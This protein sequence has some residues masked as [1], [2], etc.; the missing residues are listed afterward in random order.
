MT[1]RPEWILFLAALAWLA[2]PARAQ[3]VPAPGGGTDSA[4]AAARAYVAKSDRYL[5]H[6]RL[7]RGMKGYG[8]TVLEGIR[9]VRFNAEI[10]SVMSGTAAQQSVIMARLSGQGLEK[11]GV[12]QGMSGSPVYVRD[13]RDGKDKIIGA[14]AFAWFAQKEP[15][16]GIQ[17]ITQMLAI[18]GVLPGED[19]AKDGRK[20]PAPPRGPKS[21]PKPQASSPAAMPEVFLRAAL[22]PAK[23]DF[24]TSE[25]LGRWLKPAGILPVQAGGPGGA[26]RAAARGATL[27]PGSAIAV[28]LVA[29]DLDWSAVGTVT[30]V[31][32]DKVLAFGHAFFGQGP[33]EM[34]MSTAYVHTVIPG[35]LSSFKL[36]S[37][38]KQA[39]ALQRDERVG[40]VG[41][42]GQKA[43]MIPVTVTVDWKREGRRQSYQ[44]R[45]CRHRLLTPVLVASVVRASVSGW[46]DLPEHH[47]VR[48]GIEI[49]FGALGRYRAS[50][51]ASDDN[52]M[53]ALSD[54]TRPLLFLL[55]NPLGPPPE[56]Q[57]V[58]VH[59]TVEPKG[60]EASILK[61][62]LDG[63]VYRP[64]ETVTGRLVVRQFRRQ[65]HTL[66]IRFPLPEDLAEGPYQ[67]TA[68]DA[69]TA[70]RARI[71]QMPQQYR[72]RTVQELFDSI[73]RVVQPNASHL[74]LRLPRRGGGV[75]MGTQELPDLPESRARILAEAAK[76]DTHVFS[77]TLER[78]HK[79]ELVLNGSASAAFAVQDRPKETLIRK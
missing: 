51:V 15:I 76:L 11:T 78:S 8:L 71:S 23:T 27:A 13:P 75:A 28:P 43:S 21:R 9:R 60:T 77:N 34:P 42:I 44:Y 68:S 29:G 17:P 61:L 39:G 31:I 19:K 53:A 56:V 47:T 63:K 36:S 73:Q 50:N 46:H 25:Y 62:S 40:I 57:G 69:I 45:I 32:G 20:A 35:L 79:T 65:R 33:L 66:P 67:L 4:L 10:L 58:N 12:I 55:H 59:I 52:M 64:G 41:R 70:L 2:E 37:S 3:E 49:D 5:H 74:Y 7:R 72:P 1:V 18:S 14:V 16:C 54:T 22:N 38:L 26:A 6:D 48:Y 30:D 24:S